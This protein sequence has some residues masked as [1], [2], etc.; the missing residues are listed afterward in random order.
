MAARAGDSVTPPPTFM[1]RFV[2]RVNVSLDTLDD[3]KVFACENH[4]LGR[5]ALI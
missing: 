4:T 2:R 3:K 1:R 5:L